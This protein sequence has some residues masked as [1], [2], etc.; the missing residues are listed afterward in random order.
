[1]LALE[2]DLWPSPSFPIGYE[3]TS[4]VRTIILE[5]RATFGPPLVRRLQQLGVDARWMPPA[6]FLE[7]PGPIVNGV[8]LL[9][10]DAFDLA[11]QQDDHTRSR[12]A[13]L[14]VLD[15]VRGTRTGGG[16]TVVVYSTAMARPEVNVP[17]R[18]EEL[19]TAWY[20]VASLADHLDGI[21]RGAFDGQ[22][23]PPTADDYAALHPNLP[24]TARVAEAHQRIRG[25]P[26]A[27][28]QIWDDDAPFDK[29]AQVW[30]SRNVL[31]LLDVTTGNGYGIAKQVIRR[32]AGLPYRI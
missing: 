27:W 22:V 29:A 6:A 23:P 9:L 8:D 25:H 17:L 4:T 7:A 1:M 26:R 10:V 20:D 2:P 11:S 12:L 32:V 30:I 15:A 14:D 16:P 24:V 28:R 19:V 3:V 5:D 31:P 18:D 13:S 21:V